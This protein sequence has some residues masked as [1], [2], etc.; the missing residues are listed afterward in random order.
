MSFLRTFLD[1]T[2]LQMDNHQRTEIES[3]CPPDRGHWIDYQSFEWDKNSSW[4]YTN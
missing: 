1:M 2:W 4:D 3:L